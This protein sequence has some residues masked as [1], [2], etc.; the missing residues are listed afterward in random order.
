[1]HCFATIRLLLLN[2][3]DA[4]DRQHSLVGTY[5]FGDEEARSVICASRLNF[6]VVLGTGK[7]HLW[8]ARR[9]EN[10]FCLGFFCQLLRENF[11][12]NVRIW[13]NVT[14]WESYTFTHDFRIQVFALDLFLNLARHQLDRVRIW[15]V[16][17]SIGLPLGVAFIINQMMVVD[18]DCRQIFLQLVLESCVYFLITAGHCKRVARD[19]DYVYRSHLCQVPQVTFVVDHVERYV[20]FLQLREVFIHVKH[21]TME[22]EE[23]VAGQIEAFKSLN[24]S[25]CF[26]NDDGAAYGRER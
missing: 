20:K 26:E 13:A 4:I 3:L 1:M 15:P 5:I 12:F 25:K 16:V 14:N 7:A 19:V 22:L 23:F 9:S 2:L 8:V 11:A 10:I 21:L 18:D 24:A 6:V 17:R